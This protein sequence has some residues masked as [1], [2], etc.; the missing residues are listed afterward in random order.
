M[1]V[2]LVEKAKRAESSG[3][4]GSGQSLPALHVPT[5]SQG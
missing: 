2:A 3:A 1:I 4:D 5:E